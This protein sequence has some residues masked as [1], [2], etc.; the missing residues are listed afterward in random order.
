VTLTYGILE[1]PPICTVVPAAP[2]N[3][4]AVANGTNRIILSWLNGNDSICVDSVLCNLQG[5]AHQQG[6]P[7]QFQQSTSLATI[8][9]AVPG[10]N[11][12]CVITTQKQQDRGLRPGD[13][14]L[15]ASQPPGPACNVRPAAVTNVTIIPVSDTRACSIHPGLNGNV[16]PI[17][18]SN[19][20]LR[21]RCGN[22]F[23]QAGT[24]GL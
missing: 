15:R 7:E 19:V 2:K 11:Y 17:C 13:H 5:D 10:I 22:C 12:T 1:P 23:R 21:G 8:T 4:T 3:L 16:V 6:R 9:S 14:H 24:E 20:G 18:A